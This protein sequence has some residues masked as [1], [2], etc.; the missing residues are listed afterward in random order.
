MRWY[1]TYCSRVSAHH[2]CDLY[3][4]L[5]RVLHVHVGMEKVY[6]AARRRYVQC[7][8]LGELGGRRT[9]Y[10][11]IYFDKPLCILLFIRV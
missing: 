11:Y 10:V 2:M 6:C 8:L 3:F 4:V 5:C 7:E 1:I 9:L